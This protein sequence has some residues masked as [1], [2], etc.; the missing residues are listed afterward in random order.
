MPPRTPAVLL[1][2]ALTLVAGK[3]DKKVGQAANS[4]VEITAAALADPESIQRVLGTSLD[5]HYILVEVHLTPKS[6][7]LPVHLDDFLLKTNKDGERT[8]PFQPSQM[9]GS[10]ALVVSETAIGGMNMGSQNNGPVWGGMPGTMGRPRQ[11]PGNGGGMGNTATQTEMQAKMNT[12]QKNKKNDPLLAILKEKVLPEK[13]TDQPVSGLLYF[14]MEKQKLKDL[15]L[16][17]TTPA[18]KLNLR[19]R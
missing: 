1:L 3:H 12:D 5:N 18:G 13:E 16:I 11:L 10:D 15:E 9:A 7:K 4:D 17:Y 2:C 8:T 14:P 19:F 6:G